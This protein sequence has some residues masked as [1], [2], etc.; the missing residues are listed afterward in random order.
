VEVDDPHLSGDRR[1]LVRD[2]ILH[3]L[4]SLLSVL[5]KRRI[6]LLRDVR[7]AFEKLGL[8]DGWTLG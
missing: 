3:A 7:Y 2:S 4:R 1:D 8:I 5:E 6:R